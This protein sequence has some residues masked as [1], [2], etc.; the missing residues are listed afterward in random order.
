V[1]LPGRGADRLIQPG[2]R[3]RSETTGLRDAHNVRAKYPIATVKASTNGTG[4]L[5]F[6]R[7]VLSPE[8]QRALTAAGFL[9]P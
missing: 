7:Y 1:V 9:A 6:V 4:A 5:A 8:G 3:P 2:G